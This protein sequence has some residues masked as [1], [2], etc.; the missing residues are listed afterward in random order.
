VIIPNNS[1][2]LEAFL[3]SGALISVGE[4][5]L[6]LGYGP[7]K[8][9]VT[10]AIECPSFYFPDFF[11][12]N[13]TPWFTH[14]TWIIISKPDLLHTLSTSEKATQTPL[15]WKTPHAPL[16]Q[17]TF[18]AL[19]EKFEKEELV[20]A[21]PFVFEQTD[22]TMTSQ[23]LQR[24]LTTALGYAMQ[25]PVFLYGFW[26]TSEGILG[27]TPELLFH[28]NQEQLRLETVACAGTFKAHEM[29]SALCNPILLKEHQVVVKGIVESLIPFGEVLSDDM[30]V[31][32]LPTLSHFVTSISL[33]LQ[34][35]TPYE[36]LVRA[37]HPT[38]ALGAFPRQTGWEWLKDYQT[39]LKRK[40]FGAPVGFN[41]PG[42]EHS[43]AYVAIRNMQWD[44]C[45]IV[46]GA[47]CGLV[48]GFD[49]EQEWHEITL[50]ISAI[51]KILAL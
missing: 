42:A 51:K 41:I 18:S 2:F 47:G 1:L 20:K 8:W 9:L 12:E 34:Q 50:K 32:N 26:D 44:Q 14:E 37:V 36:S 40:R 39:K 48:Q 38:P 45:G 3:A 43:A 17:R 21:V 29:Q 31:L 35:K 30:R 7:R 28:H 5:E 46:I 16:L 33:S 19:Q 11:L 24:S 15:S 10:Q 13:P 49:R 4:G 6:L 22:Q 25:Q 23:Q 27:V